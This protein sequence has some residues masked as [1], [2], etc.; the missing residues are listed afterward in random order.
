MPCVLNSSA[1]EDAKNE[2]N[3]RGDHPAETV[4]WDHGPLAMENAQLV[5]EVVGKERSERAEFRHRPALDLSRLKIGAAICLKIRAQGF[6]DGRGSQ[7]GR[8][9]RMTGLPPAAP[10][11]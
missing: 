3:A 7:P 9:P 6:G 1:V 5:A 8:C 4:E 11:V 10:A 2:T